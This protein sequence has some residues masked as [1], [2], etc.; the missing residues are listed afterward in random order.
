MRWS[1]RRR[2]WASPTSTKASS[3][4][5]T[6]PR[7]AR[8]W[9][10]SWATSS[11]RSTCCRTW[12]AACRMIGVARE[13]AALTGPEAPL[14]PHTDVC[15][16][17]AE[18]IAGQV[19]VDIEIADKLSA[20]LRRGPDQG[21]QDRPG[22]RLDAAPALA[23]PACGRSTTSS[24]SPTTSCSNGASRCTPST[25]TARRGAGGKTPTIT[26]RPARPGEMLTTLDGVR[27]RADPGQPGSSP[28]RRARSPWPASWAG[29]RPRSPQ[30]TKNILLE[31]ANFDFVSIRRTARASICPARP[32]T[33]SAGAFIPRWCSRRRSVPPT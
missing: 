12:P 18:P 14:L 3:S 16:K 21:R 30:Q 10:T 1:A 23:T 2:S 6:T 5:K 9:P 27:T 32:V 24:T 19:K 25:T 22:A 17:P 15:R 13:V 33:A 11:W 31:S 20:P 29:R 4:W 7:S 8:R 26:V 28:T